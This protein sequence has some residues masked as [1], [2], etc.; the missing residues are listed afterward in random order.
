M[1]G[2]KMQKSINMLIGW[3]TSF[4]GM[5]KSFVVFGILV[6]IIYGDIFG[7]IEGISRLMWTLGDAG[8][9]GL[10][11]IVLVVSLYKKGE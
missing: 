5:L 6:G 2:I 7:V 3:I 8:L 1:K 4:T 11:A 9:A 10:V